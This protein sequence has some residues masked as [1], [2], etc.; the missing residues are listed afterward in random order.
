MRNLSKSK[1]GIFLKSVL[2][3][4][5][6]SVFF[7]SCKKER[8][9]LEAAMEAARWIRASAVQ[10]E[11]GRTW[12]AIPGEDGSINNTLY[13][14]TPGVILFFL[15][16]YYSTGDRSYLDDAK[17]GADYLLT[18]LEKETG[19]GLY[20]GISGIGFSFEETFR[21][22]KEEKYRRGAELCIQQIKENAIKK[23]KGVQWSDTTDII[24]G[25]AGTGLFLLYAADRL[26]D[27]SLLE[28]ATEAG[29][30]LIEL[31]V[32]E[33]D[34]L[35]WNM[36]PDY[37]RNMPN[38]SHGTAGISYFLASLYAETKKKEFLDAAL[39]GSN[40]L[41][42]I[43][44]TE[45]DVCL[46][47][48]NEPDAMD[49]YY[50]G[51]CHG[52]TGTAQ[53]F[54]LLHKVTNDMNWMDWLE[55]SARSILQSGIPEKQHPGFW[56]NVGICCGSAGVADFFLNLYRITQKQEYLDFAWHLTSHL[57]AKGTQGEK[58]LHWIQAEHRTRPDFLHA[59]TNLMQGAAGI[60]LWLLHLDS[61]EQGKKHQIVLPDSPF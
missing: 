59:Q 49:L 48:H 1:I 23:E 39:A 55:R 41:I 29:Y 27:I 3:T 8:P 33:K 51:W 4:L 21:A 32:P 44:K 16:L 60:G 30:R 52:P 24:G 53:L 10:T 34:G 13:A 58:G 26:E 28:L 38:F 36:N 31:G 2:I 11:E 19:T 17:A 22:T 5:L 15:E 50:L 18:T 35:K 25:T 7:F 54:Y 61:F 9:Y 6:L 40:Y 37:P 20:V 56:N 14:G 45:G 12:P 42:D 47:F 43:A 57:L 46:I